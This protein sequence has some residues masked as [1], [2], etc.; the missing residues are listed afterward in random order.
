MILPKFLIWILACGLA[1]GVQSCLY[2]LYKDDHFSVWSKAKIAWTIVLSLYTGVFTAGVAFALS[3][4][5]F[6]FALHE[7]HGTVA[8]GFAGLAGFGGMKV[9]KFFMTNV[10]G[11]YHKSEK[12]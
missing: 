1:G 7:R 2:E 6:D 8:L 3:F 12:G 4:L 10:F 11:N 9:L 5:V